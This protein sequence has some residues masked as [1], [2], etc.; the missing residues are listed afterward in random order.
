MTA[1]KLTEELLRKVVAKMTAG[2]P[3]RVALRSEGVTSPTTPWTWEKR[4]RERPETIYGR[5]VADCIVAHAA[6]ETNHTVSV[7]AAGLRENTTTTTIVKRKL[8]ETTGELDVVEEN[9]TTVVRP[10]DWKASAWILE[11]R[12]P[13]RYGRELTVNAG[14]GTTYGMPRD[15]AAR[16]IAERLR[17]IKGGDPNDRTKSWLPETDAEFKEIME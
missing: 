17:I 13:A 3:L 7:T 1:P 15:M 5:F 12:V 16:T 2:V 8:N 9:I 10:A 11:R 4:G 14:G 6:M